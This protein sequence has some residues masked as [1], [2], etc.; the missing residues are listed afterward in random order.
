MSTQELQLSLIQKILQL[1]DEEKLSLLQEFLLSISQKAQKSSSISNPLP[2]REATKEEVEA[3]MNFE[4]NPQLIGL[5]E[6]AKF[7]EELKVFA[8][9]KV[10][11]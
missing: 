8:K 9:I 4:K 1:S 6:S 5:E 10:T 7:L 11:K 3:I 2:A